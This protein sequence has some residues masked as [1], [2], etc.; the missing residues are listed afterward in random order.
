MVMFDQDFKMNGEEIY[1]V[2]KTE[3]KA[4][5]CLSGELVSYFDNRKVFLSFW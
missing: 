4:L 3:F 2:T 1:E 5:N